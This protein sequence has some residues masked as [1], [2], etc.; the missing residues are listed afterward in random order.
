[1]RGHLPPAYP[2]ALPY[3]RGP[4]QREPLCAATRPGLAASI[5]W[6][7][8]VQRCAG[9]RPLPGGVAVSEFTMPLTTLMLYCITVPAGR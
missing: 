2:A 1:M 6:Q 5:G 4:R 8:R 7:A 3:G 9:Q